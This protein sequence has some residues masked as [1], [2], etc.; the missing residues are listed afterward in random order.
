MDW[1]NIQVGTWWPVLPGLLA[2]VALATIWHKRKGALFPDAGL[3]DRTALAGGLLDRLPLLTGAIIVCLFILA[4]MDIS[5]TRSVVIEQTA[6]DFLVI[7]DTSR[8]MRENTSLM[9]QEYPPRYERKVGLFSGNVEDPTKIPELARYE[10]ARESLLHFKS[11]LNPQ[12]DRVGLVYFNSMI[13]LMSGFTSNFDF[14]EQQLANMDPYVTFGT[15]IRWALEQGMNMLD[16]YPSRNKQAVILL[17]D[18]EAKSTEHLQQQLDRIDRSDVSFYL[19]WITS[20]M[21][22]NVSPAARDFLQ[23]VRNIGV[24]YT[25]DDLAEGN[26]NDA[27]EE[28]ISKLENYPYQ[29]I[30]HERIDMSGFIFTVIRWLMLFW[31]LLVATV[32]HPLRANALS[33]RS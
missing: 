11:M 33:T 16:R 27:M 32:Y 22:G 29:E 19:L 4:L 2:M 25:I 31:I 26:L 28:I 15:N 23:N 18:A 24:V 30:R 5:T 14:I 12:E 8:S 9:R 6:R 3:L 17:T 13:Y 7:V 20:D 21:E 10:L 1:S